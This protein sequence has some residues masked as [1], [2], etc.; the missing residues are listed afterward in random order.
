MEAV[1]P[2]LKDM[3]AV[4][5]IPGYAAQNPSTPPATNTGGL[6]GQNPY[7]RCPLPPFSATPDTLRQFDESGKVPTRR[8]IPLPSQTAGTGSSVTNVTNV[9]S[10]ESG[11]GGSSTSLSP[12]SVAV[13]IPALSPGQVFTTT[14]QVAKIFS[15]LL[16]TT[17]N[18]VEIRLYGTALAQTIDIARL[19]DTAPPFETTVGLISDIVFDTAPYIWS[20]QNRFAQNANSPQTDTIY[21]TVVNYGT[22]GIRATTVTLTY[23][24]LVS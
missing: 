4:K 1:M 22:V 14:I 10:S 23:L 19:T 17:S 20:W 18:P 9:T 16:L 13:A 5:S 3:L 11:G 6:M 12:A 7:R 21:L 2:S 8:V 15:P 24:P